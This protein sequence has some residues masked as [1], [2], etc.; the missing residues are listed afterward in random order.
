MS[1]DWEDDLSKSVKDFRDSVAPVLETWTD[2]EN[3][4]VE[5][6][7][8]SDMADELDQTAGV[9]SWNIKR[10]DIIRGVASRVQY[11]TNLTF[12]EP[13]DTFTIR[14]E[15][16]SGAKTEFEKRLN[17]IRQGGLFPHWTTQAYLDE[18]RGELLSFARVRTEDLIRH[19]DEGTEGGDY[20]VVDPPGEASFYAVNWWRLNE[21]GIGVRKSTP[22]KEDQTVRAKTDSAQVGLTDFMTDGGDTEGNND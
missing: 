6:V 5:A 15:R 21:L 14:K 17:A 12:D 1:R 8:D 10:D 22:Y 2:S 7:T 20:Y 16:E 19:I 11:L 3:V 4:S 13:P 18:P 9:D